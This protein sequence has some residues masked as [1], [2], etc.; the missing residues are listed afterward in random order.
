MIKMTCNKSN[1]SGE[2]CEVVILDTVKGLFTVGIEDYTFKMTLIPDSEV[3]AFKVTC[4]E[5][6]SW[7]WLGIRFKKYV[8]F[9][10]GSISREDESAYCA[11]AKLAWNVI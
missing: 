6:E 7:S 3:E 8:S 10:Q 4:L 11:F 5:E 9:Y 1:W 2:E